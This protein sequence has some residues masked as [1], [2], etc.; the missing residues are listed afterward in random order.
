MLSEIL[1]HLETPEHQFPARVARA[2]GMRL[3]EIFSADLVTEEGLL[4]FSLTDAKTEAGKRL[5]PIRD[6]LRDAVMLYHE[7]LSNSAAY[8]K[9]FGRAK[10]KVVGSGKREIAFHS[11]RV[12]FITKAL[13]AG[14][15][16]MQVA[17]LVG[18]EE[19]KGDAMTGQLYHK[20]YS[21][22]TLKEIVEAVPEFLAA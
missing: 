9:R 19:G 22:Q 20:G 14:Y 11:L 18:H 1:P 6:S 10:S 4:C 5:V 15:A 21:L 2:T 13:Q 7:G 3:D 16:E 17:W 12:Q 8:S